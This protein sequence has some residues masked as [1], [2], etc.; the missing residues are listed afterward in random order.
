I[1]IGPPPGGAVV[2]K[3]GLPQGSPG[4][5]QASLTTGGSHAYALALTDELLDFQIL[6]RLSPSEQHEPAD[7]ADEDQI[8]ESGEH[9]R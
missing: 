9:D 5:R 1:S 6:G 2:R 4:T 3:T 8:Q 7:Q